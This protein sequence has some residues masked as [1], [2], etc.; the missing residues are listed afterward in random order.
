MKALVVGG[1]S[2]GTAFACLLAR[3]GHVV[4]LGVR[5]PEAARAMARD[6]TNARY[7]P[8]VPLEALVT[9]G[10]ARPPAAVRRGRSGRARRAV[11]LLRIGRVVD[12]PRRRGT[13][14]LADEGPRPG[15]GPAAARRAR[16]ARLDRSRTHRVPHRAEPRRGD[17]RRASGRVGALE[18]EPGRRATAAGAPH[19]RDVPGL[20]LRRRGRRAALRRRQ[21]R[22][23][24]GCGRVRRPR[25]RGQREGGA[26]DARSRRDGEARRGVRRRSAHVRRARRSRRP[27]R[28]LHVAPL[29]QPRRR[30]ADRQGRRARRDRGRGSAWPSRA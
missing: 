13:G 27:G 25:V 5:D 29:A 14:A 6:R 18:P 12:P 11:A 30:R 15:V 16:R 3:R 19:G 20:P 8:D 10:P 24:G 22:R 28:D 1:G 21:E 9:P 4:T 2:W 17:R 26:D 7:L 23:G